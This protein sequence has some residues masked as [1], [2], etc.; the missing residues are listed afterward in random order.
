[1]S[2]NS[3]VKT[4]EPLI[5]AVEN[6]KYFHNIIVLMGHPLSGTE[7]EKDLIL[8]IFDTVVLNYID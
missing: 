2:E 1:M 8:E 4:F 7:I 5:L 3:N 6:I